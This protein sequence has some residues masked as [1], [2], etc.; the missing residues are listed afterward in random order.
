LKN[1]EKGRVPDCPPD[2][3]NEVELNPNQGYLRTGDKVKLDAA[4]NK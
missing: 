2:L 3:G 1:N 4:F